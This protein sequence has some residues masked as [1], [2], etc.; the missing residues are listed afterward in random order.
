M[1]EG[2]KRNRFAFGGTG[3]HVRSPLVNPELGGQIEPLHIGVEIAASMPAATASRRRSPPCSPTT[4]SPIGIVP[5]GCIQRPVF[6]EFGKRNPGHLK[7]FIVRL[8]ATLLQG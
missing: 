5:G 4:I 7:R 6:A 8:A 2:Q 1:I 3:Q